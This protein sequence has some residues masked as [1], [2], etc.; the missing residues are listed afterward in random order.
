MNVL[1]IDDEQDSREIIKSYIHQYFP[2]MTVVGEANSVSSGL[3][4]ILSSDFDLLFLDIQLKHQTSFDILEKLPHFSSDIIFITAHDEY[5][6]RAI[7]HHAM[8]Y[9]LKPLERTEFVNS[10]QFYLEKS[11][12]K[13]INQ[14]E[15]LISNFK[16]FKSNNQL[17]LPTLTGFKIVNIEDILYL[18]S[19][20]NYTYLYFKNGN[21]EL[22]S[23]TLKQFQN[24]L[25]ENL[26]C[27]IHNSF[28]V[29]IN[30]VKEYIKGR[31]GQIVLR[32]NKVLNVAQAKK[33]NFLKHWS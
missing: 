4:L 3:E 20:S 12:S 26:F 16:N 15:S 13:R 32:N 27:R 11:N 23:K 29:N 21:K 10:V 19:D 30:S 24:E 2:K 33:S 7:K 6:I 17:K 25:P 1:I 9:L 22:I 14:F 31:G 18:E 28:I 8:D 5:A